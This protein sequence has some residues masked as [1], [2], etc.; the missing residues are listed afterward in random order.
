MSGIYRT[1]HFF[2]DESR[3][4]YAFEI[5]YIHRAESCLLLNAVVFSDKISDKMD[6]Q[7]TIT[8]EFPEENIK[9]CIRNLQ[10]DNGKALIAYFKTLKGYENIQSLDDWAYLKVS[11]LAKTNGWNSINE[12]IEKKVYPFFYAQA[13]SYKH[14][15]EDDEF[16]QYVLRPLKYLESQLS[17]C[18]HIFDMGPIEENA[19]NELFGALADTDVKKKNKFL[20]RLRDLWNDENERK[21]PRKVC[22]E[23]IIYQMA[24]PDSDDEYPFWGGGFKKPIKLKVREIKEYFLDNYDYFIERQTIQQICKNMHIERDTTTGR[25]K[26]TI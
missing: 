12:Y 20:K 24:F 8:Q 18:K 11:Q 19:L 3:I 15:K 23:Y 2:T 14:N 5:I 1:K 21:N 7:F 6:V 4:E 26:K 16:I 22:A 13:K 17:K 25:P 10:R 9:E